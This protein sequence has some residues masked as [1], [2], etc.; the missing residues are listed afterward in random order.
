MMMTSTPTLATTTMLGNELNTLPQEGLKLKPKGPGRN[1]KTYEGRTAVDGPKPDDCLELKARFHE[2]EAIKGAIQ[3]M[4]ADFEASKDATS[5]QKASTGH[6]M[7]PY[8]TKRDN[9]EKGINAWM[10]KKT[11]DAEMSAELATRKAELMEGF[12]AA[13]QAKKAQAKLE[14][15][16]E[17]ASKR[18]VKR[19]REA[20]RDAERGDAA[21]A[22]AELT[23]EAK[24]QLWD[25]AAATISGL[26]DTTDENADTRTY[27]L[28]TKMKARS[29][30][31]L[32]NEAE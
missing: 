31:R 1:A 2:L 23:A 3:L 19:D 4:E 17:A 25:A 27:D 18:A 24:K 32:Q 9:C 21:E 26:P 16:Q 10:A 30:A 22:V 8:L 5:G 28:Y 20:A 6:F 29:E 13:E 11:A 14:R 7:K 12:K 15:Q